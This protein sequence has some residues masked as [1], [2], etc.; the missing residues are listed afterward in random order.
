MESLSTRAVRLVLALSVGVA[1]I[2]HSATSRA[3]VVVVG[4]GDA[5]LEQAKQLYEKGKAKYATFDYNGAIDLW[6][7][8]YAT[9]PEDAD[10]IRNR[11]VYNIATAQQLA[12][13]V[14]R[15]VGHLRQAVMLL[16]QYVIRYERLH[17]EGPQT[18]A[19]VDKARE[20]IEALRQRIERAD[21]EPTTQDAQGSPDD[22]AKAE[23]LTGIV[24]RPPA[25]AIDPERQERNRQL[26]SRACWEGPSFQLRPCGECGSRR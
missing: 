15:D 22:E 26:M 23:G 6:T 1:S 25:D 21:E 11:M 17:D 18:Q 14:D 3:A 4:P 7:E 2:G 5:D 24:W 20:R 19:E 13:D 12:Y 10:W 16:E 9:I 8:A